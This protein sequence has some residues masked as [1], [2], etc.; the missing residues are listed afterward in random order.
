M[1]ISD[2]TLNIIMAS[3]AI[4]AVVVT[5]IVYWL[6]KKRKRLTY[7]VI[8]DLDLLTKNEQIKGQV[9]VLYEDQPVENVRLYTIQ[10]IN[11]G[12]VAIERTDFDGPLHIEFEETAQILSVVVI[13]ATPED[14][15]VE[16]EQKPISVAISPLLMNR[17]DSITIKFILNGHYIPHVHARIKDVPRIKIRRYPQSYISAWSMICVVFTII[18]GVWE[19]LSKGKVIGFFALLFSS[20][21]GTSMATD[22][23]NYI[24]WRVKDRKKRHQN[25]T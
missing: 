21:F 6:Q 16:I 17:R 19:Y 12:G 11:S 15:P 5:V 8:S 20:M 1:A 25:H 3:A 4:L 13:D 24:L 23:V 9:K 2:H 10:V 7:K 14:L 18:F 22:L